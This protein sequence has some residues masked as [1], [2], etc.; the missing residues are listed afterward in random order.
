MPG[1]LPPSGTP[2]PAPST[3]GGE[4]APSPTPPGTVETP[5]PTAPG[6]TTPAGPGSGPSTAP[7]AGGHHHAHTVQPSPAEEQQDELAATGTREIVVLA[8]L[9]AALVLAGIVMVRQRRGH[10]H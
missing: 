9:S 2:S 10:R 6:G 3:P 7:G 4:G 1:T 5:R 8:L